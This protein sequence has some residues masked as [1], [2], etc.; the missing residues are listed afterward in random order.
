MTLSVLLG[1]ARS[2]KSRLAVAIG[3]DW[4]GEVTFVATAEGRDADMRERIARHRAERPE[5]WHLIEEP[6]KLAELGAFAPERTEL[7]I[8]DCLSLWL[9]NVLELGGTDEEAL[10]GAARLATQARVRAG[11]VLVVTNEVGLGVVPP[12]PLGRRFRDLIGKVNQFFVSE[13]ERSFLVVAGQP[14]RLRATS[15]GDLLP[16]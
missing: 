16:P 12:T 15:L 8:V 7:V 10:E 4:V 9:S 6:Y 14:L 11:P 13:A 1:G 2:G 5:S 3:C